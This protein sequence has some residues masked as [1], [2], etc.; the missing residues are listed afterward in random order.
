MRRTER[1]YPVLL[2]RDASHRRGFRQNELTS[3]H[4]SH[5]NRPSVHPSTRRPYPIADGTP[6]HVKTLGYSCLDIVKPHF[7]HRHYVKHVAETDKSDN[8]FGPR[9]A[10]PTNAGCGAARWGEGR[11]PRGSRRSGGERGEARPDGRRRGRRGLRTR[12][13]ISL[14]IDR[15]RPGG[16]SSSPCPMASELAV[17]G[18][19]NFVIGGKLAELVGGALIMLSRH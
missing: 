19:A 3:H 9:L 6:N 5:P 4:S 11:G 10:S 16:R 18:S 7:Q 1:A 15:Y 13:P 8:G 14:P 2:V 12:W 17:V